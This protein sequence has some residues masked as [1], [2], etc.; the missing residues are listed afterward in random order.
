MRDIEIKNKLTITRGEMGEKG[1]GFS[2]TTMKDTWTK[3][4]G[5]GI[6]GGRCGWLG[7]GGV[8]GGKY[9]TVLGQQ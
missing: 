3:L 7:S 5:D 2:G 1:E 8:E 9:T 4:R 6:R